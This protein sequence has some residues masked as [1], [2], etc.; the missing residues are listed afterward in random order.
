MIEVE[1]E[2]LSRTD[3]LLPKK[4]EYGTET[5]REVEKE[6]IFATQES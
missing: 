1:E 5:R 4:L 6:T 2:F 3:D